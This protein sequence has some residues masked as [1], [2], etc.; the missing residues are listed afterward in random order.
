VLVGGQGEGDMANV[1]SAPRRTS[2]LVR[3]TMLNLPAEL[4]RRHQFMTD[5]YR[6]WFFSSSRRRESGRSRLPLAAPQ[7]RRE[8]P[9][10]GGPSERIVARFRCLAGSGRAAA[11][12]PRSVWTG[13]MLIGVWTAVQ[14]APNLRRPSHDD[15]TPSS[16]QGMRAA[17]VGRRP[18][19]G[20]GR[21]PVRWPLIF[22]VGGQQKSM[23]VAR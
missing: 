21:S 13:D 23:L 18:C 6:D 8:H 9:A 15:L 19:Q 17:R 2:T 4:R 11:A 5:G 1:T 16:E 3:P 10:R 20:S 12:E 14:P 7:P 22:P